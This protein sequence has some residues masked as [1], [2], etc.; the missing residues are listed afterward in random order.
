MTE[1]LTNS[2]IGVVLETRFSPFRKYMLTWGGGGKTLYNSCLCR[3]YYWR[4]SVLI[5]FCTR[6]IHYYM[7]EG[8]LQSARP[9]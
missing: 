1:H 9:P 3:Y 7:R 4:V 8:F 6:V 2:K 5:L